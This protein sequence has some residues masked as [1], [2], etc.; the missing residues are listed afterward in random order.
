MHSCAF[1]NSDEYNMINF[2]ADTE[3]RWNVTRN[4]GSTVAFGGHL[5]FTDIYTQPWP[6][7]SLGSAGEV[8]H[9]VIFVCTHFRMR[10]E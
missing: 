3:T 7:S 8:T 2:V 4:I 5:F 9:L 10:S 6:F 1:Y